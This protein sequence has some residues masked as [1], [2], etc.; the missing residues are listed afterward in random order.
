MKIT[1]TLQSPWKGPGDPQGA[2]HFENC[3]PDHTDLVAIYFILTIFQKEIKQIPSVTT[4][5]LFSEDRD[6]VFSSTW[7]SAQQWPEYTQMYN[8]L[9]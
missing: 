5:S 6:G 9:L 4:P 3:S 2:L 7:N 1:V 8:Q